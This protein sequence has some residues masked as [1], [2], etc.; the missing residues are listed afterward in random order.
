M[1]KLLP[2][3]CI[4]ICLSACETKTQSKEIDDTGIRRI[5]T[6]TLDE[7]RFVLLDEAEIEFILNLSKDEYRNGWVY[8]DLS[9]TT[10]DEVAFFI[11]DDK[12]E[13]ELCQKLSDYLDDC[14][15]QKKTWLESYNPPEAKKL[16]NGKVFRYGNLVGYAFLSEDE[17]TKLFSELDNYFES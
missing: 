1:K 13:D 9:G 15:L 8:Q 14:K 4:L 3:L 16:A 6:T 7:K 17:Q 11:A 10:I 2:L 5:V 12:K